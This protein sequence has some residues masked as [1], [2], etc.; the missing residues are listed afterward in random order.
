MHRQNCVE[1]NESH[2]DDGVNFVEL[3]F[4]MANY[5]THSN[6]GVQVL[7]YLLTLFTMILFFQCTQ[8]S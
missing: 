6:A 3:D 2:D 1:Q 7:M 5:H 4:L 8:T